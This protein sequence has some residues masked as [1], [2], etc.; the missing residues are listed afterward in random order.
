LPVVLLSIAVG[1]KIASHPT[2]ATQMTKKS[3]AYEL[4]TRNVFEELAKLEGYKTLEI[5]RNKIL[6]SSAGAE[7]QIDVYFRYEIF[8]REQELLIECKDY[9]KP[10]D[11][12]TFMTFVAVVKDLM[13]PG[14]F[15]TRKGYDEGNIAI[16][17]KANNIG[18]YTL[19][20]SNKYGA[21]FQATLKSELAQVVQ[22]A[23]APEFDTSVMN[24]LTHVVCEDWLIYDKNGNFKAS[25][26][27]LMDNAFDQMVALDIPIGGH[28]TANFENPNQ[29]YLQDRGASVE[30]IRILGIVFERQ[31]LNH[32]SQ[33]VDVRL[34]HLLQLVTNNKKYHVNQEGRIFLPGDEMPVPVVFKGVGAKGEDMSFNMI[35]KI[36]EQT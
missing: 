30:K 32:G 17:A 25:L 13:R 9:A 26:Q 24:N 29:S 8:G 1:D 18:L 22:F 6:T 4:L 33:E 28:I 11:K 23:F 14:F 20:E 10:V 36:R 35:A 15:V 31:I 12:P 7:H 5:T 27:S 16:L 21:K 3:T 2:S 34:T 19:D